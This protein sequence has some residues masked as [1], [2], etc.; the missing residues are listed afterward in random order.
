MLSTTQAVPSFL[1]LNPLEPLPAGGTS[2]RL[3]CGARSELR[4]R[5]PFYDACNLVSDQGN[6]EGDQYQPDSQYDKSDAKEVK[7]KVSWND[8]MEGPILVD[9]RTLNTL[10]VR[11]EGRH[12]VVASRLKFQDRTD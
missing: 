4:I 8:V 11:T 9:N 12:R 10:R 7:S 2:G 3:R 5:A 6:R 1:D